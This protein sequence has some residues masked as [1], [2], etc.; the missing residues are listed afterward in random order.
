MQPVAAGL[1]VSLRLNRSIQAQVDGAREWCGQMHAHKQGQALVAWRRHTDLTPTSVVPK[2][3]TMKQSVLAGNIYSEQW[4]TFLH[5]ASCILHLAQ[6]AIRNTQYAI[7]L[8]IN[9]E[10]RRKTGN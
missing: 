7:F 10:L 6:Y 4:S 1:E 5:L 2:S 9:R 3:R 8:Y